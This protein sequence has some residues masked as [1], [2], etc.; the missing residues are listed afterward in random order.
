MAGF[1]VGIVSCPVE[2]VIADPGLPALTPATL[3][4]SRRLG[5]GCETPARHM[6]RGRLT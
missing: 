2:S 1:T 3:S 6:P 5:Q 4:G